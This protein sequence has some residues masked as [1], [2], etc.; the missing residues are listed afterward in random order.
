MSIRVTLAL[1]LKPELT[2][3]VAEGISTG[4]NETR[5][6]DGCEEV[7]LLRSQDDRDTFLILE[8]WDSRTSYEAYLAWRTERGDMD[9]FAEISTQPY[10]VNYFDYVGA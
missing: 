5:A 4:L 8:Q 10:E 7:V 9:A 3:L 6:F 2:E 1:H